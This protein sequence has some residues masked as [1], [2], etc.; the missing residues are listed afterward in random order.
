MARTKHAAQRK[1][2]RSRISGVTSPASAGTSSTPRRRSIQ[3]RSRG[4]ESGLIEG[5]V[6]WLFRR[7]GVFK[8]PGSFSFQPLLSLE[9]TPSKVRE[10]SNFFAPKVI[11][12]TAEA[13]VAIQE[14][15]E[16]YLVH[17]FEEAMLC[18]IHAKRVTLRTWN[19]LGGLEGKAN[20]GE[21]AFE[22]RT[23]TRASSGDLTNY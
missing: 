7:F 13:L 19:W 21:K 17:L 16:D 1:L 10:I 2:F 20:L 11:R 9:L 4:G 15:A 8:R 23:V 22:F 18:A 3:E 6:Q 12:W 14:A 5:Q